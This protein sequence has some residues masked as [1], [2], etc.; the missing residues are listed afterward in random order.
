MTDTSLGRHNSSPSTSFISRRVNSSTFLIIEDD[1][2]GEQ[3]HIYV[4][5]YPDHL[6]ITDTGCNTPRQ[7][8]R[9]LTSLRQYL[10]TWPLSINGDECLNP[11]GKKR[12]IIICSHCHYD[13]ILGIPQFL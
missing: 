13:H 11:K 1:D 7:K 8:D 5:L 4:K 3:P 9:T 6:V 2:F 12:Y 10:E